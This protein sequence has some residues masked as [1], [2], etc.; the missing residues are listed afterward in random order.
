MVG[1]DVLRGWCVGRTTHCERVARL[2]SDVTTNDF[3]KMTLTERSIGNLIVEI[4]KRAI[5][6][7]IRLIVF[8][9]TS[10]KENK[11]ENKTRTK[12]D[13]SPC[14]NVDFWCQ[15]KWFV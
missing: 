12:R 13:P 10:K 5:Y 11:N 14:A 2:P 9:Q 8:G 4:K 3:L 6:K 7:K 15:S 1:T